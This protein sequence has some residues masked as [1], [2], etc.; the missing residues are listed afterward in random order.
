MFLPKPRL[1]R[2][3]VNGVAATAIHYSILLFCIETLHL[4]SAGA[5]NLIASIFGISASFL[6]NRY[7]VFQSRRASIF[8]QATKFIGI[9]IAIAALHGTTLYLWTDV[10][11]LNYNLGFIIAV[12]IQFILGYIAGKD[13][14]FADKESSDLKAK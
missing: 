3:I 6:G 5:A 10:Y 11:H 4:Q 14:V 2:Y 1:R 8:L 9:Y 7:F 12:I 13:F